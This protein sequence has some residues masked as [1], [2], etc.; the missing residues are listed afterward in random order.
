MRFLW[1]SFGRV[2]LPSLLLSRH[3]GEES[4]TS[5]RWQC[6]QLRELFLTGF[7]R[8]GLM[9]IADIDQRLIEDSPDLTESQ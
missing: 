2:N 7:C 4:K 3:D 9:Q 5:L 8:I 1:M 6:V